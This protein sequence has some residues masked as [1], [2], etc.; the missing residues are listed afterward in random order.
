MS[1]AMRR[2]DWLVRTGD[3]AELVVR[4]DGLAAGIARHV[5]D[6]VFAL[7]QRRRDAARQ[8]EPLACVV[9]FTDYRPRI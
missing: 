8:R 7:G 6:R 5:R 3:I 4:K 1:G 2:R 9:R